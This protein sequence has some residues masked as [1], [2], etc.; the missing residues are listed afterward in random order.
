MTKDKLRK[1]MSRV[2]ATPLQAKV[3]PL[4]NNR[5]GKITLT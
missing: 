1:R 5:R 4:N 3:D 2:E